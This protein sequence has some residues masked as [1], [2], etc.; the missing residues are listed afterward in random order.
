MVLYSQLILL[1][2]ILKALEVHKTQNQIIDRMP[3]KSIISMIESLG[4]DKVRNIPPRPP[5]K[6]KRKIESNVASLRL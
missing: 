2:R 6:E 5:K 4:F 1:Q 3:A